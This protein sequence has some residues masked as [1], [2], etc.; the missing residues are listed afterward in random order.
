MDASAIANLLAGVP[1][2][3][4]AHDGR[5][6]GSRG[7]TP[8]YL[9]CSST[10][11]CAVCLCHVSLPDTPPACGGG[12]VTFSLADHP[13][14]AHNND[15]CSSAAS[16]STRRRA[17]CAAARLRL[18]AAAAPCAQPPA[19][20]SHSSHHNSTHTHASFKKTFP[21]LDP[22]SGEEMCRVAEADKADV[23][24]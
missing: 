19:R 11:E 4:G 17:R 8:L 16:L 13:V 10:P 12:G 18:R 5:R 21:V 3:V 9:C 24:L 1:K 6:R 2:Q 20:P 7:L 14:R 15:S 23:D 22:R